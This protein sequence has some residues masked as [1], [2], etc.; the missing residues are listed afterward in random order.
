MILDCYEFYL[1]SIGELILPQDLAYELVNQSQTKER[2]TYESE[3]F[4]Y[5][6]R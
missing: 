5:L 2:K 4:R 3:L 1:W 6:S